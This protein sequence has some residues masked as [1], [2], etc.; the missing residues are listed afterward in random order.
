M[1]RWIVEIAI[2]K[3][4]GVPNIGVAVVP[5][6][7]AER[8]VMKCVCCSEGIL[9]MPSI[10]ALRK[11]IGLNTRVIQNLRIPRVV[12]SGG[13]GIEIRI[14]SISLR[15]IE[16]IGSVAIQILRVLIVMILVM[17]MN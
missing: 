13:I 11:T 8:W 5:R 17:V 9:V 10:I 3:C 15:I 2:S 4:R 14:E 6:L 16:S 7:N 1:T 12:E